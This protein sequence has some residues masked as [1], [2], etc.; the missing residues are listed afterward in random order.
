MKYLGIARKEKGKVVM[1][2]TFRNVEEGKTYEAIEVGADIL[3]I[4]SPLDQD[5]V[6]Q[7]QKLTRAS[8]KDHR[9]TLE[10]LAL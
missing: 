6:A 2:D 8:I 3:L 10:R 1:P 9:K 5:R 7:I 4:T